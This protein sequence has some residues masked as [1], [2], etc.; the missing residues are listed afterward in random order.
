[1]NES[2]SRDDLLTAY[3][4]QLPFEPYPAQEEALLTWFSHDQGVLFCAPTGTG[5]T[6]IAEAAMFEALHSGSKAYLTTPLIALTEQKFHELQES[7]VKW[8]FNADDIGLITGNR[9]VNPQ[10][11]VLVV[12]AEILLNRLLHPEGFDFES[13]SSVVMDEFHTFNSPD[14]G[15]VWELSLA[16]LP[17]STRLLLLSATVGNSAEFLIWLYRAHGRRLQL[18]QSDHRKV[19][20]RY[21]WI[22]DRLLDEQLTQMAAG[23]DADRTTPA[24]VFVFNRDQCWS[25]AE[26]LK[27]KSLLA[28]GQQKQ[29][30]DEIEHLDWTTGAGPKLKTILL[31]GVGV[32]H[33]GL[34]P[35]YRRRVE[36]LFQ[37]KLLS[38]CVCTETLAAGINL[39]ARSVVLTTILKGPPGKKKVI[40][41][42][43]A[44]Q[45]FGRAGR[46][47]FDD[48][49]FVYVLAHEDDVKIARWKEKHDTIP[50]DTKDPNLIKARKRIMKKMP[51]RR[52][53][54]QYWSEEQFTKLI[55]APAGKL[56]S[57]GHFPWR[58]LAYLL[59]LSPEVD[60]IRAAIR[61]RLQDDKTIETSLKQLNR[62]LRT[63]WAGG[64]ITLEPEPPPL[65]EK[66][67]PLGVPA[68]EHATTENTQAT[69]AVQAPEEPE[70]V[71][72]NIGGGM[73]LFGQILQEAREEGTATSTPN[74]KSP[75]DNDDSDNDDT[76]SV[77]DYVPL[78]AHATERLE[79]LLAFRSIN[80]L[81]GVF[82][83]DL[84]GKADFLERLQALESVLEMP[85]SMRK[86]VRVPDDLPPG[87]LTTEYLDNELIA[88]G[89]ATAEQMRFKTDDEKRDL[90]FE[91]RWTL[92]LGEKLRLL[93]DSEYPGVNDVRTI[94]V[95]AAGDLLSIGGD[96]DKYI[97]G[98]DLA[99]QEGMVFRHLL[100]L[101]LLCGE[102]EQ[103]TP[104][105]GDVNEWRDDLREIAERLTESCRQVDPESTDKAIAAA[106]EQADIVAGEAAAKVIVQNSIA[107]SADEE[108]EQAAGEFGLG[109]LDE[110]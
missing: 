4:D 59:S 62:M 64:F 7:A 88:R 98:N 6:V 72:D 16:L 76:S 56:A 60:R 3:L 104:L 18:V 102:F 109:L 35:K 24:L 75:T 85:A 61:K 25:V 100:R 107:E 92:T 89:L 5:K 26:Q 77:A 78:Q 31:R 15:I 14:R 99:R 13:V 101:I 94:S 79:K 49:G 8:G 30:A 50:E 93:F 110:D 20:L 2:P 106:Q 38:V 45:M 9:K 36:Y 81:Y 67:R 84:L 82:L 12:V 86:H 28:E 55:E 68:A 66:T 108:L 73:G 17:K 44:H 27:G 87:P 105:F 11:P 51:K 29:L 90:P 71:E 48:E 22:G 34:L 46:P 63:L 54:E 95:W 57:R 37:R 19:P 52:Q 43:G 21:N 69:A 74:T 1:M 65:P 80:P 23:E 58:L 42:S 40:D 32:H 41:A 83:T 10:A 97:R 53:T 70:E 91:E 33:A 96:F 47:Q 39:P 103:V